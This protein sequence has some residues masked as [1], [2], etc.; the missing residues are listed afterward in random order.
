MTRDE[1]IARIDILLRTVPDAL[2]ELADH[3]QAALDSG[4]HVE[5]DWRLLGL[6]G[7]EKHRRDHADAW[8]EKGEPDDLKG[9]TGRGLMVMQLR[10]ELEKCR[11]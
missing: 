8:A 4:H 5:G 9:Q 7:N 3:W 1:L 11:E 2:I 6:A 10:R